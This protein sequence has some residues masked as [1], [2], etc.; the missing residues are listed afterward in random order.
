MLV[1]MWAM[2]LCKRKAST[3]WVF[4]FFNAYLLTVSFSTVVLAAQSDEQFDTG[5]EA[6]LSLAREGAPTLAIRLMDQ[7]QPSY[8][9]DR[10]GWL[11]WER[12]RLFVF[13]SRQQWLALV[14][15]IDT[16]S[17][18]LPADF[19][20]WAA[21]Q[22]AQALMHL[23]RRSEARSILTG[24]LLGA[25][26]G[27]D[28]AGKRN[29]AAW[30][31]LIIQSYLGDGRGRDADRAMIRYRQDFGDEGEDWSVLRAQVLLG[32]NRPA[33]AEGVLPKS[34]SQRPDIEILRLYANLLSGKRSP[35]SVWKRGWLL[36]KQEGMDGL[37]KARLWSLFAQVGARLGDSGRR[38]QALEIALA[39]SDVPSKDHPLY[40]G[41][42]E[43]W[44]SYIQY[45][46]TTANKAQ[47]LVG[48]NAAWKRFANEVKKEFPV[49]ERALFAFLAIEAPGLQDR[50]N[51]H[52]ELIQRLEE[53]EGGE[54]IVSRLYR[55]S[56]HFEND[57]NI[58]DSAR[59][60]IAEFALRKGD[61]QL[62]S[63]M[64]AS[65]QNAP[66]GKQPFAWKLR[67]ARILILGGRNESGAES[68]TAILRAHAN[69]SASDLDHFVQVV[70]DLQTVDRDDLALPLFETLLQLEL[71]QKTRREFMFWKAESLDKLGQPLAAAQSYLQSAALPAAY[72]MDPWAQTARFRAAES[73]VKAGLLEDARSV[74]KRLLVVSKDSAR[75]AVLRQKLQT[76]VLQLNV[77]K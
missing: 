25:E 50:L 77:L 55:D 20:L 43:L 65:L 46:R 35:E 28:E 12:Q 57:S 13:Q 6:L 1:R 73:L 36:R 41:G 62:A 23:E 61:I 56:I 15:R 33:L 37:N 64:L 3:R 74:F 42:D 22:R 69:W 34:R 52:V 53:V 72:S 4:A 70:F 45:G 58:P 54:A 60:T 29:T 44:Q 66:T 59:Q 8:V 18:Q 17:S 31:R 51:A 63:R 10:I 32:T 19:R 5:L 75:K 76:L 7:R 30:R 14:Q 49:K 47:L 21:F 48:N 38:A 67:R 71:V 9:E 16:H 68:L 40:V 39:Q 11:V 26:T 24:L 27:A 2:F